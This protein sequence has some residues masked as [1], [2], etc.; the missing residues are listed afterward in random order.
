MM[1]KSKYILLI[2]LFL[3][4][5][6]CFAS[7]AVVLD[8]I[9]NDSVALRHVD[10]LATDTI[11][12]ADAEFE[13]WLEEYA[14]ITDDSL[15][16]DVAKDSV[17]KKDFVSL[18]NEG[19][20]ARKR[21]KNELIMNVMKSFKKRSEESGV[22]SESSDS[23]MISVDSTSA[24]YSS[25]ALGEV[26]EDRGDSSNFQLSTL[27]VQFSTFNTPDSLLVEVDSVLS[28][29]NSQFSTQINPLFMD[30][31]L[32]SKEQGEGGG[33]YGIWSDDSIVVE[34]RKGVKDYVRTTAPELYTYHKSDLPSL[35]ELQTSHI[36]HADKKKLLL[37]LDT[38]NRGKRSLSRVD[39]PEAS[40]WVKGAKFQ[41][42]AS[43][44]YI[45]SNWYKGGE[46]NMAMTMYAMGYFNYDNRKGLQWDNKAEWKLGLYGMASDSLRWLR[47]N[48]DLLR[49]NS[50]LG[51][52]A[53]K[54]FYYTAEW[55]FQTSLF[56]TYKSNTYI[57]T[58][59]PFSPIR[60]SLSAGMDYKWN[61]M[62]SVFLS[63]LSYKLVYVADMS[64]KEG[65]LL[66]ENIA[67]QVGITD[68]T[69]YSN[70]LGALIRTDFDYDFNESIGME[71]HFSFFGN[72]V[73]KI[74]GV[75]VGCEV[76]G[77]FKINRF[78]SAKVSLYPRYDST[79][80]PADGGKPKMQFY[81]LISLGFNYKL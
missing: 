57:R 13:A 10:S 69:R 73:G 56:N 46:S 55:D 14:Q 61:S 64:R 42:H 45:S 79:T 72:Y 24:L 1:L 6:Q 44:N 68:G 71:V 70:Q 38:L 21:E 53:F 30:W 50:K 9:K 27:N 12:L 75:E 15:S 76:I 35:G 43:Q 36:T 77:N 20:E 8:S 78:L 4:G 39:L 62:V 60:M 17:E 2:I 25:P 18:S 41:V 16:V 28:T 5:A 67:H 48:E 3:V 81:E 63:P 54:N 34:V 26:V 52:K 47:V 32:G 59:G 40:R 22:K 49:F 51:Y 80:I 58:S 65:V 66:E 11:E 19:E 23:A 74:K 31:V 7:Q 29:L 33:V 37:N